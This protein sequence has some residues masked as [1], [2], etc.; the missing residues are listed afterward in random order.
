MR[1]WTEDA[2]QILEA[3]QARVDARDQQALLDLFEDP[4]VLI[5]TA[6]DGRT[7]ETR[8]EYLTAV[9]TQSAALRWEWV[10]T[11]LFYNAADALGFAAFGEVVL[12]GEDSEWRAPIRVTVFAVQ[13]EGDWRLREF[14]G[15]IPFQDPSA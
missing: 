5:G 8:S 1:N 3:L 15:S 13:V 7:S 11:R 6:G 4:A 10:E 2:A 12:T 9:A 14:H